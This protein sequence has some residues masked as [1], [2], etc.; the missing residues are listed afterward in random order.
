[1]ESAQEFTI[2]AANIPAAVLAQGDLAAKAQEE[3]TKPAEKP[4]E[5]PAKELPPVEDP[6]VE[7][8]AEEDKPAEKAP[9]REDESH[10]Y[11]TLQGIFN[12]YK[13][14]SEAKIARLEDMIESQKFTISNLNTMLAQRPAQAPTGD[15]GGTQ[16]PAQQPGKLQR[17]NLDDFDGYGEEMLQMVNM[18]NALMDKIEE[19]TQN[20]GHLSESVATAQESSLKTRVKEFEKAMATKVH[21]R[22]QELNRDA[23]F[24]DWLDNDPELRRR[25]NDAGSNLDLDKASRIFNLFI[26]ETGYQFDETPPA[27]ENLGSLENMQEPDM[28]GGS[29]TPP[30]TDSFKPVTH[31]E[32]E[33][34]SRQMALGRMSQKDYDRISLNYQ[35]TLQRARQGR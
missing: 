8:K 3:I 1:M 35:K 25:I 11:K 2:S 7:V 16:A 15:D 29:D 24:I 21:P 13:T 28:G 12:K 31:K 6:S 18:N 10:R 33:T 23:L 20:Q 32:F 14:D 30:G 26:R 27:N 4:V 19:L 5:V 22:W 17:L 9:V 34:A